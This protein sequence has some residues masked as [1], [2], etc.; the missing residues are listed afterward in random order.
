MLPDHLHQ[1]FAEL[2]S[3][4]PCGDVDVEAFHECVRNISKKHDLLDL[5]PVRRGLALRSFF[6]F[7]IIHLIYLTFYEEGVVELHVTHEGFMVLSVQAQFVAASE[8]LYHGLRPRPLVLS[9]D[10]FRTYDETGDSHLLF[11]LLL[12]T[13]GDE[14]ADFVHLTGGEVVQFELVSVKR[15]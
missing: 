15:M 4:H 8:I 13:F 14:G 5:E 7:D 10:M 6:R 12:L 9:V 11:G 2:R 3:Q 1:A